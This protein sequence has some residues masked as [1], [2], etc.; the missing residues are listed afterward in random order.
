MISGFSKFI[1]E[2]NL[3]KSTDRILLA[4]SGGI[5]SMVM[6]N[7]FYMLN[8][9]TGIA[10]CNFMLRGDESD[11]DEEVVKQFAT[12]NNLPFFTIRFDT[13]AY[14]SQN[15]LSIQMAARELRYNWFEKTRKEN[16][17]DVIAVAHNLNDNIETLLINLTR[18]TGIAGM[19]GIR[20]HSGKIIRPILFATRKKISDFQIQHNIVFRE[21]KSNADTKYV[22]N[23]I[24]HLVIP[25]LKD[26]N[27]SIE[28]TLSE[29][30]ERFAG[31]YEIV[32][33]YISGIR[34]E[35]ASEKNQYTSFNIDR[36]KPYSK[37]VLFELLKP[38]G[39]TDALL[40]DLL[41][42]IEGESGSM[43]ITP[44]HRI[45]KNRN[46]LI[47]SEETKQMENSYEI[48]NI[49]DFTQ[50]PYIASAEIINV[51]KEYK[52]PGDQNVACLDLK[53]I[54]FPLV[55]RKWKDGDYF[56]PLGMN[57]KK[58]LSDYF[59]DKKYSVIDKENILIL[60]S[61]NK[62][63]WIIGERIDDRFKITKES[64][65]AL[66]LVARP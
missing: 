25:V 11:K 51:S 22:R 65:E 29:T 45:I 38:Y 15:K 48:N 50:C 49:G 59:I 23:K 54:S 2:N 35:V 1:S 19:S 61:D 32:T 20:P 9:K 47:V 3:V 46:E 13:K 18:G 42:I 12:E 21:D 58:K 24:R 44:T 53:V 43:I 8:Y 62:I 57:Q 40:T 39:I 37:S 10:H 31:F 4:V 26:I 16:G 52:I 5:D 55:I 17:Y 30:A 41:R 14:A 60:E 66:L 7:L 33:D 27:P 36:L 28:N 56:Y 64:K 63:V 6:A 34:A